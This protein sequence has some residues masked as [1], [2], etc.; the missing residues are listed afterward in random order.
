M[1]GLQQA[2]KANLELILRL[3]QGR[4]IKRRVRLPTQR[5]AVSTGP[6]ITH[7]MGAMVYHSGLTTYWRESWV[8]ARWAPTFFTNWLLP[9]DPDDIVGAAMRLASGMTS[10]GLFAAWWELLPWSWLVDWWANI[11]RY[12]A[13]YGNSFALRLSSLCYMQTDRST[14]YWMLSSAPSW[15]TF[16]G[17]GDWVSTE[18]KTRIPLLGYM[19]TPLPFPPV[20]PVLSNRQ[21][22][23]LGGIA[24]QFQAKYHR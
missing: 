23:I 14:R 12:L 5:K 10:V 3:L 6:A 24:E 19:A 22:G 7:S 16:T 2:I 11:G 4:A 8:T 15:I 1:L 9:V 18:V 20:L 13:V 21:A 17:P